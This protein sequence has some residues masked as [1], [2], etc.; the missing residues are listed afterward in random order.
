MGTSTKLW[1]II[2]NSYVNVYQRVMGC[3]YY[4]HLY[5]C[6][7]GCAHEDWNSS[8]I[9]GLGVPR[10]FWARLANWSIC[11]FTTFGGPR[12]HDDR[13]CSILFC[14][15]TQPVSAA[16]ALGTWKLLVWPWRLQAPRL[17]M[18]NQASTNLDRMLTWHLQEHDSFPL[19]WN[20]TRKAWFGRGFA[21]RGCFFSGGW[22]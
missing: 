6:I 19:L 9:A 10:F 17:I 18:A 11:Q 22:D 14:L 20:T 8:D 2:F 4:T 13:T 12:Y 16:L 15:I 7:Y 21:H 3:C 1:Y 5:G